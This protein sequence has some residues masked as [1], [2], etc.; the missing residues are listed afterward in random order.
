MSWR[1]QPGLA[2]TTAS[3]FGGE[4]VGDL[5]IPELVGG[6]RLD[7]VVDTG[8]S[9]A[10]RGLGDLDDIE[11]GD[12]GEQLAGLAEDAL[13]VPEMAGIVVGDAEG[14]GVAGGGGRELAEDLGDVAAFGG[15]VAGADGP[16]GV[17]AEKVAVLLH[18]GS[19]AGGVDD[20]G[21]DVGVFEDGDDVAGHVGGLGLEAGVEHEGAAAGLVGGRDDV[22]SLRRRG[23]GRWRR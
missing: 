13:R 2:E 10:E 9:A 21:I 23:R 7:E 11:S 15:E 19:A 20:D 8:G 14:K 1:R 4:E 12:G 22:R 6:L 16:V 18:G 3:G 17:V 5:A